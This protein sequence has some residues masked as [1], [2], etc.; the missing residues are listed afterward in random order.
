MKQSLRYEG[1]KLEL[2]LQMAYNHQS[3]GKKKSRGYFSCN[4]SIFVWYGKAS[5][6]IR[7]AIH[8][9]ENIPCVKEEK[10]YSF[11]D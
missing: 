5:I 2:P 3:T 11:P 9:F 1:K 6:V 8:G 10:S 4:S 7:K